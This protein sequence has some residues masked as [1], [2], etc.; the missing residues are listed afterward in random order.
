MRRSF[1]TIALLAGLFI[2]AFAPRA[3]AQE[4]PAAAESVDSPSPVIE[5]IEAGTDPEVL[6]YRFTEGDKI[7][8]RLLSDIQMQMDMGFGF[9]GAKLPKNEQYLSMHVR[10]VDDDGVAQV[11]STIER[12][13]IIPADDI[14]PVVADAYLEGLSAMR[15][16]K[17]RHSID[18]LGGTDE[19]FATMPDGT[20]I[21]DREMRSVIEDTVAAAGVPLPK[22]A[23][24][25]GGRWRVTEDVEIN[26]VRM[27]RISTHTLTAIED[28]LL[29]VNSSVEVDMDPHDVDNPDLPPGT[30]LRM[31]STT[32]TGSGTSVFSLDT[33]QGRN[34]ITTHGDIAMTIT[35]NGVPMKITQRISMSIQ[36]EPHE[37]ELPDINPGADDAPPF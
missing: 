9:Q 10:S 11:D 27:R 33:L 21:A 30:T 6:R 4:E 2:A 36:I 7:M 1:T 3:H 17:I 8:L 13:G 37:G 5:L 15:G 26:G 28:G 23:I 24:G 31:E 12:I 16:I 35:Q 29:H 25:V 14:D 18:P 32:M 20:P 34:Q 19:V 22:E